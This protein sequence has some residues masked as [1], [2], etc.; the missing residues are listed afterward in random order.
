MSD[1]ESAEDSFEFGNAAAPPLAQVRNWLRG[2][3]PT[4]T[5]ET[6]QDAELVIT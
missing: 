6:R 5:A 2:L 1:S 4:T 3:L